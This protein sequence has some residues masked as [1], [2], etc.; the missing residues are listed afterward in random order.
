[1][2]IVHCKE[3]G[4][5]ESLVLEDV[6]EPRPAAGQ[7][8]I[9][10]KAAGVNFPDTLIIQGMYQ[11]RPATPFAPGSEVAGEVLELGAGVEGLAVG[12]RVC[13]FT[14]YGGY[15][16]Q[17]CVDARRAVVIPKDMSWEVA[18]GFTVTYATTWFSLRERANIQPGETL[19]VLGAAGGVGLTAVQLGKA[20]GARVIAAASTDAKLEVTAQHGADEGINYKDEDLNA[21]LRTLA[22]DGLDVVY[23]PVGGESTNVALRR[24]AWNGRLLVVGFASGKIPPIK[25]NLVLLKNCQIVGVHWGVSV[26]RDPAGHRQAMTELFALWAKGAFKP[27]VSQTLPLAEAST[28]LRAILDRKVRGKLILTV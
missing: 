2:R 14:G 20:M 16:E 24:M 6:A 7:V 4:P 13:A 23:D 8:R 18:A 9:G 10:V 21:R 15:A 5:P 28:A 11:M 26:D 1:M 17:V 25:A 22:P 19:L 27:L 3:L 12:D